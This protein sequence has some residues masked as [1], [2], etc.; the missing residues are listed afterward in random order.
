MTDNNNDNE[1][2]QRVAERVRQTSTG[3]RTWYEVRALMQDF[4]IDR[5]TAD[6]QERMSRALGA[7]GIAIEPDLRRLERRDTVFLSWS[8]GDGS[9]QHS[10]RTV[11]PTTIAEAVTLRIAHSGGAVSRVDFPGSAT[12][13]QTAVRW[14]DIHRAKQLECTH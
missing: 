6:A 13:M 9:G 1:A 8:T 14:F 12:Q 11:S 2:A 4:A 7:A 10:E 5:F 3:T